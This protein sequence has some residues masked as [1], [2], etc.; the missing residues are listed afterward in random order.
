VGLI[1]AGNFLKTVCRA[2][3]SEHKVHLE[4]ILGSSE[5]GFIDGLSKTVEL[6]DS[7]LE[8]ISWV[9]ASTGNVDAEKTGVSEVR[10]NTANGIEE[11]IGPNSLMSTATVEVTES[12]GGTKELIH[13]LEGGDISVC[14]RDRL[15]SNLDT[16]LGGFGPSSVL[17]TDVL[18]G[19]A[20]VVVLRD[21]EDITET[22]LNKFDVLSVVLDTWGNDE[23]LL[24]GDVIHNKLL[25]R[26]G[27]DLVNFA[28]KSETRH[29]KGV[30]SEGSSEEKFLV[31]GAWVE[32]VQVVVEF[33]RLLVLWLGDVGSK[34]WTGLKSDVN[35][36]LEHVNDVVLDAVTL[37]VHRF[38]VI[39]HLHVTAGHL[40]HTV[41]DSLVGVLEGLEV[42]VL[43]SEQRTGCLFSLISGAD[44]NHET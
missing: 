5:L 14:P 8:E 1:V 22:L 13:D 19:W 7:N 43:K 6:L 44:S 17:S 21:G 10:V 36:H 11:T 3:H 23:A 29:T 16:G 40:D 18:R 30:V 4:I 31:V 27:V 38:L 2:L 9:R 35:H 41:V 37:E 26:A 25:Q 28:R 32:Q 34:D 12:V 20:L 33:V 39:V 42:S 15:E 24:G